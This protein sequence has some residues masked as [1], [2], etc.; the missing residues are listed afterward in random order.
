[1]PQS[2]DGS[3]S[4][5]LF[6]RYQRSEQAM[7]LAMMEMVLQGGV[8]AEGAH[9][10]VVRAALFEEHGEPVVQAAGCA[11]SG[12]QG[13]IVGT[14]GLSVCVGGRDGDQGTP[15]RRGAADAFT[16]GGG[17][18]CGGGAGDLGLCGGSERVLW[19]LECV[20]CAV[21]GPGTAG[22]RP[23]GIGQSQ[24]TGTGDCAEFSVGAVAAVP[25]TF[26]A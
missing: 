19:E 18:Q 8:D 10:R 7:V 17:G 16:F 6:G 24:G 25:G 12:I 15:G 9:R 13:T 2:R 26:G 21:A 20:V 1:M 22:S 4:T 23:G 11:G 3:F 14:G 5:E